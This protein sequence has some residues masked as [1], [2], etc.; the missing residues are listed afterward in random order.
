MAAVVA[1]KAAAYSPPSF[2]INILLLNK[3]EIIA[4]KVQEKTG[5]GF[6][7]RAAAHVANKGVTDDKITEKMSAKLT[8]ALPNAI[9]E[10]GIVATTEQKFQK[11]AYIVLEMT[12]Q[13]AD[14]I[15][16]LTSA[17]GVEFA[18]KFQTL[19]QCLSDLGIEKALDTIDHTVMDKLNEGLK[20]KLATILPQKMA[21]QGIVIDCNVCSREEQADFFFSQMSA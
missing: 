16:L 21:E 11:G 3:D 5:T 7:G 18:Q 14:K 4:A 8:E 12:V 17:K 19:L 9:K 13:S 20:G 2:Y 10:M 15:Q 6:F 1:A